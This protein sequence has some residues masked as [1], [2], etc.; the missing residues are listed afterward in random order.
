MKPKINFEIVSEDV[1]KT[2]TGYSCKLKANVVIDKNS[3][4]IAALFESARCPKTIEV[5]GVSMYRGNDVNDERIGASIARSKAKRTL[6]KHM[7]HIYA[8][9]HE[10][11]DKVDDDLIDGLYGHTCRATVES[12]YIEFQAGEASMADKCMNSR[13]LLFAPYFDFIINGNKPDDTDYATFVSKGNNKVVYNG[14][15]PTFEE[16]IDLFEHEYR[17]NFSVK[18]NPKSNTLVA[19]N[20]IGVG[21]IM[22]I[23]G[24]CGIKKNED[25]SYTAEFV[26]GSTKTVKK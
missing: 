19:K 17:T 6:M 21:S 14:I 13:L 1:Q 26:D 9:V 5:E 18:Y 10:K 23:F 20:M 3:P 8:Q 16:N 11:L 15:I 2:K 7:V 4:V 12:S 25:G 24:I 22:A